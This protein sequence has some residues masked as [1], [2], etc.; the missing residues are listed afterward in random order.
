[1]DKQAIHDLTMLFLSKS[2]KNIDKYTLE[3]LI[4]RYDEI[5]GEIYSINKNKPQKSSVSVLKPN[6]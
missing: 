4:T 1:M 3:Q 2:D 6:S 5:Y